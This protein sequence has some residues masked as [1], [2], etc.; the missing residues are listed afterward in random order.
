MITTTYPPDQLGAAAEE[1]HCVTGYTWKRVAKDL[2]VSV[3]TLHRWR[4][5]WRAKRH[6][7][8]H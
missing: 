5:A 8:M 4:K 7:T 3:S 2:G 1:I 6:S